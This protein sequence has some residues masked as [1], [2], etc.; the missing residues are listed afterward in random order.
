MKRIPKFSLKE[1]RDVA[2]LL[3]AMM[4][5][6]CWQI[7]TP[8]VSVADTNSASID[9]QQQ[10]NKISSADGAIPSTTKEKASVLQT[11]DTTALRDKWKAL[12]NP[13]R[14]GWETEALTTAALQKVKKIGKFIEQVNAASPGLLNGVATNK[15]RCTAL[16]PH[17]LLTVYQ[18]QT[19]E[20][21]RAESWEE[22]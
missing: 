6:A 21:Q 12:D 8:V 7:S 22:E 18:D 5:I 19:F 16:L 11:E 3:L 15:F 2:R 13:E 14:D 4:M 10:V 9:Q 20:V 1:C 17:H